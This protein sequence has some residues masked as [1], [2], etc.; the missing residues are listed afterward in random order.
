M[1]LTLQAHRG[2]PFPLICGRLIG[3]VCL[4]I[5]IGCGDDSELPLMPVRSI[6]WFK[7]TEQADEQVRKLAGVVKP[8]ETT[9][10]SFEVPGKV[11]AVKVNLGDRLSK[12]HILAQLDRQPFV[13]RVRAA[14]ATLQ[15]AKAALR[16]ARADYDRTMQLY[17]NDNASK[18]DLDKVRAKFETARSQV[19]AAEAQL[20]LGRRD[21]R[22]TVL[23]APFDGVVASKGVEPF[24]E[25]AAGRPLFQLDGEGALEVAVQLPDTLIHHLRSGQRVEVRFPILNHLEVCGEITEMG[26]HAQT[27]NAFPVTVTLQGRVPDAR[28]GM[29]AEVAFTYRRQTDDVGYMIP[30]PAVLPG[31]DQTYYVFV[32]DPKT[33]TVH[34]TAIEVRALRDNTIEVTGALQAGDL[35]AAAGVEFLTDNQRVTLLD[36]PA[37]SG[38][39]P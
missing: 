29:T 33:S 18:A 7:V 36:P 35:I 38:T 24:E 22:N 13:L 6:K 26:S 28:P 8:V 39:A 3:F 15:T 31:P 37:S 17:E 27:A 20:D 9:A 5:L 34:K 12:G 1:A 23:R 21:L 30:I 4:M 16:E 32:F 2:S 10:L 25:I 19:R 11:A 14:E